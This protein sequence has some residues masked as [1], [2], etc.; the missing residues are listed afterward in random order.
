[1]ILIV[2]GIVWYGF[3]LFLLLLPLLTA[4]LSNPGRASQ[5]F[6]VEVAV[7]AGFI[8]F[9]IMSLEFAL[10][11]RITA[12]A[13]PFGEDAL[14]QFHNT[15][16]IAALGF[17]LAHPTLLIISGYPTACWL[18]PFSS[19]AN[20]ATITAFSA[21]LLL[22]L[23]IISSIWRK[24]LGIRYEV[25]YVAHGIFAL[26]VI[27]AALVH[28]FLIGRYT[29]TLEMKIVWAL[30]AVL[31]LGLISWYKIYTPIRNWNRRWELVENRQEYGD[32]HT[33]VLKP[34]NHDGFNFKPGQFS[35]IKSGRTPFG[36]GQHPISMSSPGDVEPSGTVSFTIKNLGDWSGQVVPNLQPGEK[37]WLDGPHGVF[38]IDREQ[39]MGYVFVGGG[40]GITPLHSMIQ[41]M[42]KREDN[43]K[44]FLFYGA[45]SY[46]EMTFRDEF[47]ALQQSNELNFTFVP[48]LSHP[49]DDW[50]GE[51]GFVNADIMKKH[52]ADYA[53]QYKFFKY[54]IC[55][56]PAL[57]DAME[58]ALPALGVP[59][60]NVLTERFDMV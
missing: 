57:M 4:A 24:R 20:I 8:G 34:E 30:Y 36:I 48:V 18:N 1:M 11:S 40:V 16:G 31:V 35:W 42:I 23:L 32:A 41:T 14:Q 56:P 33:L 19:C 15:M 46:A 12:A 7:G 25:W 5:P 59:P 28:I 9:S 6:L 17:V 27:F 52:M 47:E 10:I 49:E 38:S 51:T 13:Q 60:E 50:Q 2:R 21:V 39:A 44:V 54:L 22:L 37:V 53:K 3:Y 43:R 45:R 55:G 26:I 58:E 29:S